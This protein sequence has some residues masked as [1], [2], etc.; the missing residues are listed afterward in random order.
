[1]KPLV[2]FGAGGL[3][4]LALF[5]FKNDSDFEVSA[6]T[7]HE[8]YLKEKSLSGLD[9]VPA[10][11][12]EKTYPPNKY[13]M[14]IAISF[15]GINKKR[16]EI[17]ESYK[18]KGYEM[19]TYI[20]S[21]TNHW[22]EFKVGDNCMILEGAIIN[23]FV[24]IGNNVII[25]PG[26]IVSHESIV[27]NHCFIGANAVINGK[28]TIGDY[29]IVGA[30]STLL[31]RLNIG[32]KCVIGAGTTIT[33]DMAPGEVCVSNALNLSDINSDELVQYQYLNLSKIFDQKDNKK[34]NQKTDFAAE[35][36]PD[37]CREEFKP[38][39][40]TPIQQAFWAGSCNEIFLG[41]T[42]TK[43][44]Y[45]IEMR[46]IDLNKLSSAWQR[47]VERHEMLRV[48]FSPTGTQRILQDVRPYEIQITDLR[49]LKYYDQ[50][51][52]IKKLRINMSQQKLLNEG[53]PLFDI[54]AVLLSKNRALL[55]MD[56]DGINLDQRSKDIVFNEWNKIY[57]NPGIKL[58]DLKSSF[59][60]YVLRK[61]ESRQS[62]EY[63][64][65]LN[66]WYKILPL[67]PPA[68]EL[69]LKIKPADII[70]RSITRY[71]DHLD[72]SIWS[73][74]KK[75]SVKKG[76]Q[77]TF[78][79]LAAFAETLRLWCTKP[80]MTIN[81]TIVDKLAQK[82][83]FKNTVGVF[84]SSILC[85]VFQDKSLS[86]QERAN[87]LQIKLKEDLQH[88]NFSSV[89][90]IRY[91]I[92][93][94]G[95]NFSNLMPVVFTSYLAADNR[96]GSINPMSWLGEIK[97]AITKTPQVYLD[98]QTHEWDGKFI[99]YWDVIENLFPENMI[100]EMFISHYKLLHR[101]ASDDDIWNHTGAELAQELIP[102][103][104][105]QLHKDFNKTHKHEAPR[106]I[107]E[108]ILNIAHKQPDYPAIITEDRTLTYSGLV[109]E[110][111]IV[112]SRLQKNKAGFNK[113]AAIVMDKGWEQIAA[114]LGI[115][116]Y[117]MAYLP[118]DP[119]LPQKRLFTL[120]ENSQVEF[121]LTQPC[122]GQTLDWPKEAKRLIVCDKSSNAEGLLEKSIKSR[123]AYD[124]L[125]YV[126]Y[127]SGSTGMPKGVMI[128]H[129]SASNTIDDINKRFLIN[130]E[131]RVI[132]VSP[133]S[134]DLSVY[135]IFGMLSAGGAVVSPKTETLKDP[136]RLLKLM[137]EYSI[138]IWNSAPALM[139]LLV[140]YCM[141]HEKRFND[142]LRLVLLSGDWI[143]V[144]LPDQIRSIASN[145][146]VI[147]LGGA[148]E[149]S[150]WSII[151]P[152]GRVDPSWQSIPYGRPMDN[153]RF[154][155]LD[156]NLQYRPIW[157]PG[158]LY[159]GGEGLAMGYLGDTDSTRQ[160]FIIHPK[161]KERI[162]KA[163]DLGRMLP[164]GIIE[165]LGRS[166]CQVKIR[167]FRVELGE[168]ETILK[169]HNKV[170]QAVVIATGSGNI[171]D[172]L[173][174]FVLPRDGAELLDKHLQIFVSER[175]PEYMRP[176]K[177]IVVDNFKLSP[178]GKI[179]RNALSEMAEKEEIPSDMPLDNTGNFLESVLQIVS[180]ILRIKN[181]SPRDYI[182]DL[183]ATSVDIIRILNRIE[184]ELGVRPSVDEFYN[185][186]NFIKFTEAIKS[187]HML[188][189]SLQPEYYRQADFSKNKASSSYKLIQD[190]KDRED[191]KSSS[192]G[193]RRDLNNRPV[194]ELPYI[195]E[196]SNL[197]RSHHSRRTHRHFSQ[198]VILPEN[199]G[200]LL[201]CLRRKYIDGKYSYAYGSAGGLYPVQTYLYI[202]PYR[203]KDIEAGIYYYQPQSH[204]LI[205]VSIETC[206][207]A[208]IYDILINRPIFE[209]ASFGI[210]LVADLSAIMPVYGE[211]S[212][213]YATIEAGLM[214]Q[215]LEE[216]APYCD[217]G[218][219]Q[220]G[221]IDFNKI[222]YLFKLKDSH[223]L[224]HSLLGG[225]LK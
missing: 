86:F 109:R 41:G 198:S 15:W 119:M 44:Y 102:Q 29:C 10:E 154:Y 142:S 161:S 72:A 223:T 90:C 101:L 99:G 171:K 8:C 177:F 59:R 89:E 150:I 51:E 129:R 104:H 12:I 222:R 25:N 81:L 202:K 191:F 69:P 219:C 11:T 180:G 141:Q 113:L 27:G 108:N 34:S 216:T 39:P 207:P 100:R 158:E 97:Y 131:D 19:V 16:A 35:N 36:I 48:A 57:H 77:P 3:A 174:A 74:F 145:A 98:Y 147:S 63:Q 62:E 211:Q 84:T 128:S 170:Q 153:Q 33:K 37:N 165:F 88:S 79:V 136:S 110:A 214:A 65:D 103:S 24:Q 20:S 58:P 42:S 1:M 38:F 192:P 32:Q 224:I 105:I 212:L 112:A 4:K 40:L 143:P 221:Q 23:P 134:F 118:L 187:R 122:Y 179:D 176:V 123:P 87:R 125:A 184:Q 78:A 185:A 52:K 47:L 175:L 2:I 178:N 14:F 164:D 208:E 190:P 53:F 189:F 28:T 181:I 76:L 106:L 5:Y 132:S 73:S 95:N 85:G 167:G 13:A 56:F 140:E 80:D 188:P 217:I 61:E 149:S 50:K 92:K 111:L 83:E 201:S 6:F 168:I 133:L 67:L 144:E 18:R 203:I 75:R 55:L 225:N 186:E 162:Y 70:E 60:D 30:N 160:S 31:E 156:E 137:D 124:D 194:I 200:A 148:T 96:G 46:N 130:P 155:V 115:L 206:V 116:I 169:Q 127:T 114:S 173:T 21:K 166:D 146:E 218:L 213:H 45:E 94:H 9:V 126:I 17:Y 182:L 66:Y 107:H 157:V 93:Q 210:F 121:I 193:L 139:Q 43:F 7:I 195:K 220:I 209:E 151:Y 68:P 138:T 163:G 22:G 183:G 120:L 152:I 26:A 64:K 196:D 54:R 159:I 91:L 204:Q 197:F 82:P 199:M 172:R 215:L 135:D 117:G 205:Q 49:G 71:E